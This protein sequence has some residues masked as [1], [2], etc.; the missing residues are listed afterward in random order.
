MFHLDPDRPARVPQITPDLVAHGPALRLGQHH[1]GLPAGGST[2]L[3]WC[4]WCELSLEGWEYEALGHCGG[5]YISE[6]RS[7]EQGAQPRLVTERERAGRGL[8]ERR[9][10]AGDDQRITSSFGSSAFR[11]SRPPL[12][13]L[14]FRV[15]PCAS[16]AAFHFP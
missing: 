11:N 3:E 7:L 2:P 4:E 5:L 13:P 9:H 16:K 8:G 10:T 1:V 15:A 6:A 14:A 12:D